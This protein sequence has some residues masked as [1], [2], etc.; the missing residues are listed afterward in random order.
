MH[1]LCF[2]ASEMFLG[3]YGCHPISNI[4]QGRLNPIGTAAIGIPSRHVDHKDDYLIGMG[5][6]LLLAGVGSR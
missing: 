5:R 6:R 1:G 3:Q 2:P 4:M